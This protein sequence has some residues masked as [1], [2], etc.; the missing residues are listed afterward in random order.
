MCV[1]EPVTVA[2]VILQIIQKLKEL[3]NEEERQKKFQQMLIP[4]VAV[5]LII[6]MAHH[7]LTTPV[8]WFQSLFGLSDYERAIIEEIQNEY[9]P[10]YAYGD[11]G[12]LL[13]YDYIPDNWQDYDAFDSELFQR[14]M[15]EA[16]KFIGFPY[17]WGGSHPS[18]SFDCSGFIWWVYRE[19][20]V[21]DF[22][23][24]TAQGIFN[25]TVTLP[26]EEARA[27]DLVFFHSTYVTYRN[28]THV[29]I[30]LGN[31]IMLHAGSPI[32]YADI[33]T[34]FWNR[35]FYAFGRVPI[36]IS[37]QSEPDT[38]FTNENELLPM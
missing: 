23:R 5:L 1:F 21:F 6:T 19:A 17:V 29:G 18:T 20:G 35:H 37:P 34:P 26:R 3:A 36:N 2:K 7:I 12:W 13:N 28:V 15:E 24:T 22:T 11:D 10:D 16:T 31:G 8:R 38:I 4:I 30:Y 27:G 32:G 25:Q 9:A 14:L 33:T